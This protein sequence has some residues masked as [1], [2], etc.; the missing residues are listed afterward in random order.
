MVV[1][2]FSADRDD[3]YVCPDIGRILSVLVEAVLD[4]GS[5]VGLTTGG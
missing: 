2:E 1:A 5:Q 3:S 4:S